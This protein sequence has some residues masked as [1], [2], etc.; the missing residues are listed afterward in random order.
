MGVYTRPMESRVLARAAA[1]ATSDEVIGRV[2]ISGVVASVNFIPDADLTGADTNSATLSV[3]NKGLDGNGTTVVASKAFT[4]AVNAPDFDE[5]A[6][7]LSVTAAD[8]VVTA[9]QVLAFRRTK[10]GTGL[11]TPGG[12][13]VVNVTAS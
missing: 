5:T 10:V 2:P 1:D 9:G 4:A 8:L 6:I 3:V 13:I 12:K 11:A 7:T